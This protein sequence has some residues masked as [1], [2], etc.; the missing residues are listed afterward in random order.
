[1]RGE[2]VKEHLVRV[3]E[4]DLIVLPGV[5]GTGFGGCLERGDLRLAAASSSPGV[6]LEVVVEGDGFFAGLC[7]EVHAYLYFELAPPCVYGAYSQ[8]VANV[9]ENYDAHP[10]SEISNGALSTSTLM[11]TPILNSRTHTHF[12]SDSCMYRA[13]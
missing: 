11:S 12:D 5:H 7:N 1:M 3:I 10:V 8:I 2:N 9:R 6:Q 4:D 13:I